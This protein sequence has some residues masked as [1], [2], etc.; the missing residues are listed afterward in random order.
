MLYR[1]SQNVS[2]IWCLKESLIRGL[3]IV[4]NY[5]IIIFYYY[6]H[7]HYRYQ[8]SLKLVGKYPILFKEQD[9]L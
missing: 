4:I 8:S 3:I 2:T 7:H 6:Y 1:F 9:I 5:V